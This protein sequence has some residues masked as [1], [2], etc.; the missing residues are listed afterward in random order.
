MLASTHQNLVAVKVSRG[1]GHLSI[2][3]GCCDHD[4]IRPIK[5]IE[6]FDKRE[7]SQPARSS[8]ISAVMPWRKLVGK[9]APRSLVSMRGRILNGR[10][11]TPPHARYQTLAHLVVLALRILPG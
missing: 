2:V 11:S 5:D 6:L 10:H 4:P 7:R 3:R 8:D 9:G 1:V